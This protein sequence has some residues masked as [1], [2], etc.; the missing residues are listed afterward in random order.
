MKKE[1]KKE[2]VFELLGEGESKRIFQSTYS[3][4]TS[5]FSEILSCCFD[6]EDLDMTEEEFLA[7]LNRKAKYK[8]F[9]NFWKEITEYNINF[10]PHISYIHPNYI[11]Y[12]VSS[13]KE[14]K[15]Q[16]QLIEEMLDRIKQNNLS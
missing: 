11:D 1:I 10:I 3:D 8:T 15:V 13:L 12:V 2:L 7:F 16:E 6:A 5:H 9:E 4:G 14:A